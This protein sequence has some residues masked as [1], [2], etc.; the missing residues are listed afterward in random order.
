MALPELKNNDNSVELG[1]SNDIPMEIVE[2][3]AKNRYERAH[4]NARRHLLGINN[5]ARENVPFRLS[6]P[7]KRPI[8]PCG[9][10]AHSFSD[11]CHKGRT[12]TDMNNGKGK[13]AVS[14]L[15]KFEEGR[16]GSIYP[17]DPYSNDK[18][19]AMQLLSLMDQ[20]V[21]SS[22][23]FE[24]GTKSSLDKPF[25]PC[26]HHPR[27][28]GKE[29]HNFLRGSLLPENSNSK[30]FSW[31]RYGVYSSGESSERASSNLRGTISYSFPKKKNKKLSSSL[32]NIHCE[33][34]LF[35][36]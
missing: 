3:L 20:R 33:C 10:R 6:I 8:Q 4:G 16:F 31:L 14:D 18:I 26:K 21:K 2:L 15:A 9:M 35:F 12:I 23:S 17:L 27:L 24:I 11:Q 5:S 19:P 34:I 36:W 7:Q 32:S 25:S 28:N 30:D 1:T 22:T 29:N 13:K